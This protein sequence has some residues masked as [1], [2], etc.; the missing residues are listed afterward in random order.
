MVV[1]YEF[2]DTDL[3]E[4]RF[5][6]S[7][8]N[9]LVL[10]L[11][12][13]RDPG[14]FPAHLPWMHE[15]DNVRDQLDGELL[16]ALI[17][18][19]MATPDF[20][21]PRPTSPLTRIEDQ[22]DLLSGTDLDLITRTLQELHDGSPLPSPLHGSVRRLRGRIVAALRQYWELCF[23][24]HWLRIRTLL[25]ADVMFRAREMA[26]H[27]LGRMLSGL[28]S[29]V[30]FTDNVLSIH[31]KSKIDY[32]RATTGVGL[33]L[34]PTLFTRWASIPTAADEPPMIHYGV[35]GLGTLWQ[36]DRPTV[37]GA[38]AALIGQTRAG[39][40]VRLAVPASSTELATRLG[41]SAPA[42]NQHLRA[43]QAAGLLTSARYGRAVLYRRSA[44][45]DALLGEP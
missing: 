40:L 35:R 39:L 29:N 13:W 3:A 18:T 19:Q 8:L 45:G 27:G 24:P 23:A 44:L 31:L 15:L 41:V 28:D 26:Q 4:V 42:V 12:A 33:T 10:S 7:P 17:N 43:L 2:A 9:D 25:E 6:I 20:L 1:R 32:T 38:I 37:P 11:R 21:L 5:A 30:H 14:R 22:F 34:V 16:L 36:V